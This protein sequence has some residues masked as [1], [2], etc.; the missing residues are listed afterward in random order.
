MAAPART[1]YQAVPGFETWADPIYQAYRIL[2]FG[3]GV[4]FAATGMDKFTHLNF[5]T[6]WS[7]YLSPAFAAASPLSRNA[8]MNV[9]GAIEVTLAMV[10]AAVPRIGAKL[11]AVFLGFSVLNL[12]LLGDHWDIALR[13]FALLLGAVA[14]GRLSLV[15]RKV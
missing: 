10:V 6:N 11:I 8:T 4:V 2:H 7:A 5:L 12:L 1:E 13:D 15:E 9:V 3:Y 14:L